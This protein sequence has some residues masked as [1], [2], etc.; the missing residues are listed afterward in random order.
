MSDRVPLI[1]KENRNYSSARQSFAVRRRTLNQPQQ[2][3][4]IQQSTE[5]RR[6][7]S[8][9]LR[10]VLVGKTG[11]G[12]SATGNTILGRECFREAASAV[13]VTN[14]CESGEVLIDERSV[15]VID[16]PGLCDTTRSEQ[17]V[18]NEIESCVDMS[19]PG[20]HAFLLLIKVGR[21]TEEEKNTVKW[22]QENFGEEAARYTI[23]LFTHDDALYGKP[24]DE[25]INESND[26]KALVG[27]CGGRFHSFNN[28]NTENRSQ[29]TELLEKIE[30]MVEENGGLHYTNEMYQKA[31][32]RIQDRAQ[33]WS[34]IPRIVL[35]GKTGSGTSSTI[36]IIVGQKRRDS[37][38]CATESC[39]LHN[40]HVDGKSM[41]IIDT[42]GLIDASEKK[43]KAEKKK[44]VLMSDPGP[45]VFLLVIKLDTIF[46]DE[47]N[48]EK[49]IQKNIGEDAFLHTIILFTH[50]DH[51]RGKS[52]DQYISERKYL[53]SLVNSCGRRYIS[54]NNHNQVTELLKVIGNMAVGNERKFYTNEMFQ[55]IV[56]CTRMYEKIKKVAA[57]SG[58]GAGAMVAG[59]IALG[60]TEVVLAPVLLIVGGAVLISAV[61]AWNL[62]KK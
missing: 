46:T 55:K 15:S 23:I 62:R 36:E 24:L 7:A 42:P 30:E 19:A 5:D 20:P 22:I 54:F 11:S 49:W 29:V 61:L 4:R 56:K 58:V 51:L 50:T 21:F 18:K 39:K 13:S 40:V 34:E 14:T 26:L 53:Q 60:V 28:R 32:R 6:S 10:I 35:L 47:K 8:S 17:E 59:G 9:K 16:T 1:S 38:Y 52:I 33:F 31:Q 41:K 3:G 44:F 27:K 48:T 57:Q 12:K 25:Y 37:P 43:M 45:D 2:R